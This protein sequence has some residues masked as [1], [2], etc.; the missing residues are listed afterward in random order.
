[1]GSGNLPNSLLS[2]SADSGNLSRR[3]EPK[4]EVVPAQYIETDFTQ[5]VMDLQEYRLPHCDGRPGLYGVTLVGR[6]AGSTEFR[7]MIEKDHR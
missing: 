3:L 4:G 7:S 2:F 6:C 1:M 5:T